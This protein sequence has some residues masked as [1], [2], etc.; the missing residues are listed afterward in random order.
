MTMYRSVHDP[1][2][3]TFTISRPEAAYN[4][5]DCAD[6]LRRTVLRQQ[7][8]WLSSLQSAALRRRQR[9]FTEPGQAFWRKMAQ[10]YVEHRLD[11]EEYTYFVFR[12]LSNQK[13]GLPRY[14]TLLSESLVNHWQTTER[15]SLL[16]STATAW[17]G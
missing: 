16:R 15:P 4:L 2:P 3:R 8:R 6:L 13:Q 14:E 5:D 9:S 17:A 11:F 10:H 7:Q 12:L 1:T